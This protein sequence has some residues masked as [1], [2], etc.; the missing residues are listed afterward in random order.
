MH[1]VL[2]AV[3]GLAFGAVAERALPVGA[4]VRTA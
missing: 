3:I 1:A 4:R 2:W